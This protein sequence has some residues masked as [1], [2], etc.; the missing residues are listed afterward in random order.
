MNIEQKRKEK[1]KEEGEVYGEKGG[2]K[3]KRQ[4]KRGQGK[5]LGEKERVGSN[6]WWPERLWSSATQ[7]DEKQTSTKKTN[8]QWNTRDGI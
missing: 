6:S 4:N 2:E 7:A 8:K 3:G 5:V 1:Q